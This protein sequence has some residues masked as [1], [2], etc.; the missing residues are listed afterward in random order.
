MK[1]EIIKNSV[2]ISLIEKLINSLDN[3]YDELSCDNNEPKYIE[4][5]KSKIKIREDLLKQI[6]KI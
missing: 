4:C 1:F 6:N 3:L 5:I 2:E